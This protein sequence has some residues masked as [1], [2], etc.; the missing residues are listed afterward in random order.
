VLVARDHARKV[1][2]VSRELFELDAVVR[3]DVVPTPDE[4]SESLLFGLAVRQHL[5]MP[6]GVENPPQLFQSGLPSNDLSSSLIGLQNRLVPVFVHL[7]PEIV[8]KL[9]V[10]DQP[11]AVIGLNEVANLDIAKED[12]AAL[13]SPL[14]VVR[15][16]HTQLVSI[17]AVQ[18][19]V[20][21]PHAVDTPFS[22]KVLDLLFKGKFVD[23]LILD[24]RLVKF[25]TSLRSA[26]DKPK[27]LVFL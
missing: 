1:F 15:V 12:L 3:L 16:E 10:V 8:Q 26:H 9:P 21:K 13:E 7:S 14:K 18:H 5:R 27:I 20:Q 6:L 23:H 17:K 19:L 4:L 22:Q 11:L 2:K 24:D 25:L